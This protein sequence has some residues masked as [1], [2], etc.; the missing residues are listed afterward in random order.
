MQRIVWESQ[1]QDIPELIAAFNSTRG[2]AMISISLELA[3]MLSARRRLPS[4]VTEH[5][6]ARNV[7]MYAIEK[8]PSTKEDDVSEE[9]STT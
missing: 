9:L 1:G 5:D 2:K 7:K 6:S 3:K 4:H 8:L